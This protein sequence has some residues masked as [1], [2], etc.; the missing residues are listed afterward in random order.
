MPRP[1][2]Q[3]KGG[4]YHTRKDVGEMPE[5]Q[6]NYHATSRLQLPPINYFPK[7]ALGHFQYI[8]TYFSLWRL[9]CCAGQA[10]SQSNTKSNSQ[11]DK[12]NN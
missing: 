6:L 2:Q 11:N 8:E 7:L 3:F 12:H 4:G 10:Y 1:F 5:I 9:G